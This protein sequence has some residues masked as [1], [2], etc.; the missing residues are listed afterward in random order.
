MLENPTRVAALFLVAAE[1]GNAGG[2]DEHPTAPCAAAFSLGVSNF[3]GD[4]GKSIY[5]EHV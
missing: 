2:S 1:P 5:F 4:L 3:P